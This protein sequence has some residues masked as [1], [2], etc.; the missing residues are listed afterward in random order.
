MAAGAGTDGHE[1]AVVALG[2]QVELFLVIPD[3]MIVRFG[4]G[5]VRGRLA[6]LGSLLGRGGGR[7]RGR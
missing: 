5:I 4:F 2:R 6:G 3:R 7:F 1:F